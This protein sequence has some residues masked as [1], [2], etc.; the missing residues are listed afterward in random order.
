MESPGTTEPMRRIGVWA[1]LAALALF[2]AAVAARLSILFSKTLPPG[3][4]AA[5]YPMQAR[6]ILE[7]GKLPYVEVPLIFWLD[8]ALA[9]LLMLT[10]G[11]NTDDAVLLASRIVDGV[12]QPFVAFALAL[13]VCAFADAIVRTRVAKNDPTPTSQRL[14]FAIVLATFVAC[15]IAVLSPPI[16]RMTGDFQKNSLGFVWMAGSAWAALRAMTRGG[17]LRYALLAF[18]L[19]LASI[20]HIGA[21]GVTLVMV[22]GAFGVFVIRTW[23]L[24]AKSILLLGIGGIAAATLLW[25]LMYAAAPSKAVSLVQGVQKMFT[26][27]DRPQDRPALTGGPDRPDAPAPNFNRRQD[28]PPQRGTARNDRARLQGPPGGFPAGAMPMRVAAWAALLALGAFA[29]WRARLLDPAVQSVVAGASIAAV[30]ITCPLIQGQYAE[31]LG[32]MTPIPLAII[33]AFVV[34]DWSL[35]SRTLVRWSG[36]ATGAVVGIGLLVAAIP[37]ALRAGGPPQRIDDRNFAQRPDGLLRGP[38]NRMRDDF[39]PPGGPG[40]GGGGGGGGGAVVA[41]EAVSEFRSLRGVVPTDGT[42]IVIARHGLQWWAGYFLNVPVREEH[43]TQEQLAKYERVY[44]LSEKNASTGR[45]G[46]PGGGEDIARL[47]R[48]GEIV[49]D[50]EFYRLVLLPATR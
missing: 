17:L 1:W 34:L 42:A 2:I 43:A 10:R 41:D 32:L 6:G 30:F 38:D 46:P 9:K 22:A 50:G 25:L 49:H 23:K 5:Y 15:A 44:V 48:N 20:T 14:S 36:L 4:D 18:F 35:A 28:G 13:I 37:Q 39:G 29:A 21:F 19:A 16:L 26:V 47:A 8:A 12:A 40:G 31:R 7:N 33:V 27:G 24:R 3:I 11:M 45:G